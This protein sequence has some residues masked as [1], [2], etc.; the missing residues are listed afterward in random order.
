MFVTTLFTTDK[1]QNQSKCPSTDEWT[2]M[3]YI[4]KHTHGIILL[5]HKKG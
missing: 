1:T 2:K 5:S 3:R 4:Y